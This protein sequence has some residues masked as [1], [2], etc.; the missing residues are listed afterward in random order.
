VSRST[1]GPS[2]ASRGRTWCRSSCAR[3]GTCTPPRCTPTTPA[4]PAAAPPWPRPPRSR[5]RS[6][7]GGRA[8]GR[9]P[10]GDLEVDRGG[11]LD[12]AGDRAETVAGL[13]DRVGEPLPGGVTGLPLRED[14][15]H[16]HGDRPQVVAVAVADLPR[17]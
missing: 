16:G 15:L 6:R 3:R 14:D 4:R 9:S 8:A 2:W 17:G 5:P 13:G 1:R 12:G 10:G 11:Q 7:P